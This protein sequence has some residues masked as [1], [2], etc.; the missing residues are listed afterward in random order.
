MPRAPVSR[1]VVWIQSKDIPNPQ[2]QVAFQVA[3]LHPQWGQSILSARGSFV[4]FRPSHLV[5]LPSTVPSSNT[6]IFK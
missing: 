5:R 4:R 6:H 3:Y 1:G 2:V